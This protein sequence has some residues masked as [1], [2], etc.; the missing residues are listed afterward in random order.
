MNHNSDADPE[1]ATNPS[2]LA[3][4]IT[5]TRGWWPAGLSVVLVLVLVATGWAAWRNRE[6]AE[7]PQTAQYLAREAGIPLAGGW[8]SYSSVADAQT[9]LS[10]E[11]A[12][13]EQS[14]STRHLIRPASPLYPPHALDTLTVERYPLLGTQGRL[15]LEFFNDRLYEVDFEPEDLAASATQLRREYRALRRDRNG[16]YEYINGSFRLAS[17]VDFAQ[18]SVGES[19]RTEPYVLWQDL[20][21]LRQRDD[22]DRDFG[23]I[24]FPAAPSK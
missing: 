17:N 5:Q 14:T 2:R 18:H 1:S 22:W 8:L 6:P 24:P 9:R 16:R 12:G 15:T 4:L 23:A 13:Q 3:A 10:T 20:R 19:L 7:H 11:L 21:L